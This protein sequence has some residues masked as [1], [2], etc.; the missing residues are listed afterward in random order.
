MKSVTKVLAFLLLVACGG[1]SEETIDISGFIGTW[2]IASIQ[3]LPSTPEYPTFGIYELTFVEPKSC[4]LNTDVNI[5]TGTFQ[6]S[7]EKKIQISLDCT[8]ISGDS[9]YAM[10][11]V[12]LL[13]ATQ[14]YYYSNDTLALTGPGR[15]KMTKAL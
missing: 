2:R 15:V 13:N 3:E 9:D 5:C 7:K 12:N 11:M 6:V 1:D 14:Y 10:V 4:S 8:N